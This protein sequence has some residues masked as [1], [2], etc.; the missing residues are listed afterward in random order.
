MKYTGPKYVFESELV[1]R[2]GPE[3]GGQLVARLVELFEDEEH[4][5]YASHARVCDVDFMPEVVEYKR[6]AES[7]CCG[8]YEETL[9]IGTRTFRI[10]LNYGH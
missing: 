9:T 2:Y 4:F 7:G 3:V 6:I 1:Q 10:G 5:E 8:E